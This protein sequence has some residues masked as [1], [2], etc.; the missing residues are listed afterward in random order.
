MDDMTKEEAELLAI[1]MEAYKEYDAQGF[2]SQSFARLHERGGFSSWEIMALLCDRIE[3][4][5]K[6]TENE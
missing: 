1:A 5:E 4:L 3:R 6:G 2:G